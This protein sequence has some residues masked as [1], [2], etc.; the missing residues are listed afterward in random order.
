MDLMDTIRTTTSV[1]ET[2]L[3]ALELREQEDGSTNRYDLFAD[4]LD[5]NSDG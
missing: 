2:L 4:W 1:H 3:V 5:K